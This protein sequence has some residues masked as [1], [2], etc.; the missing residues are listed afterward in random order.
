MFSASLG[1]DGVVIRVYGEMATVR[2]PS[3]DRT[4]PIASLASRVVD[5]LEMLAAGQ[6]DDQ[7]EWFDIR[8]RA[9]RIQAAYGSD[10]LSGLVNSRVVLR[11]HQIFVAHR[12][13][14]KPRPSIIIA[15]E[16]GLGKTIEAGLVLKELL[17][18]KAIKRI[19]VIV[20]PNLLNQ[21]QTELRV[22]FNELFEIIDTGRLKNERQ[23]QPEQNPWRRFPK[24]LL[25]S[26]LARSEELRGDLADADW[27]LVIVD[28]AHHVRRKLEGASVETTQLYRTIDIL[29]DKVFGVLLLTATPMQL[30]HFELFGLVE[31]VEP[32]LYQG[33]ADFN[34]DLAATLGLKAAVRVLQNWPETTPDEQRDAEQTLGSHGIRADLRS[35]TGRESAIEQILRDSRLTQ[36]IVRNRKRTVGGFTRRRAMRL[37]VTLT[38][39]EH[40]VHDRVEQYLQRGFAAADT[41]R[42][43]LFGFEL[44]TYQRLMASSA[45]ALRAALIRR[46][47]RL[48]LQQQAALLM[49][50]DEDERLDGSNTLIY[51]TSREEV[52]AIDDLVDE[53]GQLRESKAAKLN[54]LV[55]Q[56]LTGNPDEKVLVFTQYY[57]TQD[58]LVE[59]L[60]AQFRVVQFRGSMGRWEKDDAVRQF[61][62]Q[63]QVMVS[64][65]AGGEG[66]NFQFCHIV[67][68]YDLHWNPMRIEQRIGRLDRYGQKSEVH[69]YNI[70][71]HGTIEDRLV[72]VLEN[73]LNLFESTVGAL[74][75]VLG[76]VED[77]L[78]NAVLKARGDVG[79]AVRIFERDLD[80]RL[81][82]AQ[83]VE[84]KSADF[85]IEI[86]SFQRETADRLTK[87]LSEGRVR[88]D[89]ELL[90][91]RIL[92]LFP[93]AQ[94]IPEGD[95]AW[96]IR[97]PPALA[98]TLG[99]PFDSDYHGTFA[100]ALAVENESLDFFGFGHPLVDMCLDYASREAAAGSTGC[101]ALDRSVL[102]VPA[103]ELHFRVEFSGV[104]KRSEVQSIVL[105]LD[106]QRLAGAEAQL[107]LARPI[108]VNIDRP[109][110][111]LLEDLRTTAMQH[112]RK[113][114]EGERPG[115]EAVNRKRAEEEASRARRI[116]AY[117]CRRLDERRSQ[118]LEQIGRIE[119]EASPESRRILPALRGR[120]EALRRE[121]QSVDEELGRQLAN[122][123]RL[124]S[125]S[126][127]FQLLSAGLL[128]PA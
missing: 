62:E 26:H 36:S 59:L 2:F 95:E 22:K 39:E 71:A 37:P 117:N 80:L 114:V 23:L 116:H 112:L 72:D 54:A 119:E 123:E 102:P 57:A 120:I 7:P 97:T 5:P 38:R 21:W 81:K 94:A 35:A 33:F 18:R 52:Q 9:A 100:A 104:R 29:K 65:E 90:V 126:E 11:P 58:L 85:V 110:L 121:Q 14:E 6:F 44:V 82:D 78:R 34:D 27:D 4:V 83:L 12:I 13:L 86:G 51:A 84:E 64:T 91:L 43:R 109:A 113:Y 24:A 75:L 77:D 46:K 88:T 108:P 105:S 25:S 19:L 74:E 73:R 61:K 89:L 111:A 60:A 106:G 63:A 79:E 42:D 50:D 40:Q 17:A 98:A 3:G 103:V 28:E 107:A 20:P 53:L 115:V 124:Q 101:R 70:V 48:I 99:R 128:C 76:E 31:I 16:V 8:L 69:I 87:E 122:L 1:Q 41:K 49:T 68:N 125:V 66:R 32:G 96:R 67:V 30:H 92:S 10:N 118:M 45:R 47:Q 15:D 56:I 93:T 127:S 55:Q